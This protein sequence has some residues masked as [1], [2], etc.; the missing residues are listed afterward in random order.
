LLLVRGTAR[1]REMAI[2]SAV[3]APRA[4]L[5]RQLLVESLVLSVTAGVVG[6][7]VADWALAALTTSLPFDMPRIHEAR[8][9]RTV[10]L[11]LTM[12]SIVT[13]IVFGMAP[14]LQLS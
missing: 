1:Q 6:V 13:G 2:R 5:V 8:I 11:F 9:D 3:G 12:V 7:I 10:L 4:R 14:A